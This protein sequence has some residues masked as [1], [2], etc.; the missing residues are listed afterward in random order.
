MKLR[1]NRRI[2]ARLGFRREVRIDT[3]EAVHVG[4]IDRGLEH[5]QPY[6]N[7]KINRLEVAKEGIVFHGHYFPFLTAM[8][9]CSR[10]FTRLLIRDTQKV[11][12]GP[13]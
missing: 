4:M 9:N 12:I 3:I 1:R 2:A 5:L 7:G 8:R 13:L 11:S 10:A 6:S